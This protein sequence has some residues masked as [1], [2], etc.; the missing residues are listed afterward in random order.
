MRTPV[1][2]VFEGLDGTGKS[3]LAKLTAAELGAELVTTPAPPVRRYRDELIATF[4]GSQEATQLF[5][6]G[7]VFA[8]T[9]T[10]ASSLEAG[11]DVV[12][13][14][15]FVSTQAY[16]AFRGSLLD[17]DHLGALL[18]PADVTVFAHAPLDVRAARLAA[19]G[20][21]AADRETLSPA[22]DVRLRA[23][24]ESRLRL[25]VVGRSVS[26]DTSTASAGALVPAILNAVAA[27]RDLKVM[28]SV[29]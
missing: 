10:I 16:A 8:A 25:S 24:H 2:V 15:Y 9:R 3:T 12:C 22:A 23:E 5:Y 28:V 1:L 21:S 11:R 17:L 7:T 26:L 4:D 6:L 14:R 13:D 27:A 20:G 19:R 29:L 18:V